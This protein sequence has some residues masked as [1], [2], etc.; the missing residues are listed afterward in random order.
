MFGN[1]GGIDGFYVA[2][3]RRIP[4]MDGPFSGG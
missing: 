3:L 2:A 1:K 4:A